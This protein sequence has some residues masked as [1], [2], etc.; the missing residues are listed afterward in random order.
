MKISFLSPVPNLSGGE[1]V[2]AIYTRELIRRGHE[3]HIYC[4]LP[5][6]PRLRSKVRSLFT[7]N[8]WPRT[9][10]VGS[11]HYE[12]YGVPYT[13]SSQYGPLT[14]REIPDA[15]AIIATFWPTADWLLKYSDRK[16][17]K[18]YLIQSDEG[19]LHGPR[20]EKTYEY[21]MVQIYVSDWIRKRICKRFP[22]T[23]G[24]LIPNSVDVEQFD[25]GARRKP[26]QLTIG[27]TLDE[28]KIKGSDL[29]IL[30]IRL[31]RQQGRKLRF[32]AYGASIPSSM[33]LEEFDE[34]CYQPSV[35][36]LAEIYRDCT[37]WIFPSRFDGFGLPILEAM[38]ARTPVI[39]TATGAASELIQAGGGILVDLEDYQGLA[40]AIQQVESMTPHQWGIMSDRAYQT[41][42]SRSWQDAS[43]A[44]EAVLLDAA[45][46]R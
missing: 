20:A 11:S 6:P 36:K 33:L 40:S 46:R 2:I 23:R 25:L 7:G 42:N 32:I 8:G 37:A 26:E 22:S 41:A 29:A 30:A 9:K 17:A 1:R 34:F 5:R 18:V 14:E 3:V 19:A 35:S 15:D 24:F 21:P 43:V 4:E 31:L 39:G 45:G 12:N 16:G 38:A 44:F 27:L 10:K 28:N 13:V